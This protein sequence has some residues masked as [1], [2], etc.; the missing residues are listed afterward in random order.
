MPRLSGDTLLQ[1]AISAAVQDRQSLADCYAEGDPHR[2]QALA[3]AHSFVTLQG[4]KL[5][6]LSEDE[7]RVAFAVFLCAEQWES[8]FADANHHKGKAAVAAD[9]AARLYREFRL[10]AFGRS[11]LEAVIADAKPVDIRELMAR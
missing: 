3:E 6:E 2:A 4:R 5:A 10:A 1:R 9:R 11:A 8:S 7:A